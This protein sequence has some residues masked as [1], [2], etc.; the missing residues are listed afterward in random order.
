MDDSLPK[1]RVVKKSAVTALSD[2]K[3]N[4]P[5]GPKPGIIREKET[6]KR[7][8]IGE[9]V[10]LEIDRSLKEQG[11][12]QVGETLDLPPEVQN[13]GVNQVSENLVL[14]EPPTEDVAPH[15]PLTTAQMKTGL[16]TKKVT[17]SLLWLVYWCIRQIKIISKKDHGH[18][19]RL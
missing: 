17:D 1:I 10:S 18:I 15:I 14:F 12:E 7:E 11:V 9:D 16:Q 19:E 2:L 8:I 5:G 3:N 13:A 4:P 6:V